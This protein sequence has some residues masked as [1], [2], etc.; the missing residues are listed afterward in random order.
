MTW[1]QMAREFATWRK[2][3][4]GSANEAFKEPGGHKEA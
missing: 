2:S 3:H 4:E 1:D